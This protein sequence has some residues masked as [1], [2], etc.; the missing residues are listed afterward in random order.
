MNIE[1]AE[2][3]ALMGMRDVLHNT[4]HI[5]V[6]WHDFKYARGESPVFATYDDVRRIL[7]DHHFRLRQREDDS[8]PYG[9]DYLSGAK[10]L[11]LSGVKLSAREGG[12]AL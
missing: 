4:S 1:G 9:R 5:V 3:V 10:V 12:G 2:T 7:V 6:A 11:A 8:R